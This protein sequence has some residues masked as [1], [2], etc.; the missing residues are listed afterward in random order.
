MGDSEE[1]LVDPVHGH[2]SQSLTNLL[3][4]GRAGPHVW[5]NVKAVAGIGQW[6]GERGPEGGDLLGGRSDQL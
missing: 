2:G 3:L 1:S 6:A 4:T 5:D